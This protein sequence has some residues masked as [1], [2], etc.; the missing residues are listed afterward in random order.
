M[1]PLAGER[2]SYDGNQHCGSE[3]GRFE[4]VTTIK[5]AAR[6]AAARTTASGSPAHDISY[7]CG[8]DGALLE[9]GSFQ[10][11]QP[12]NDVAVL[13]E[14]PCPRGVWKSVRMATGLFRYDG[15]SFE[16]VE[17]HYPQDFS[18]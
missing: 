18:A 8:V 14:R 11:A 6:L 1:A 13:L 12:A 17:T 5:G 7:K 3:N 16:K 4:P 2:K 15:S 10:P 9:I